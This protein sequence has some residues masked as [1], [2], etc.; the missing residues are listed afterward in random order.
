MSAGQYC[1]EKV[2]IC[3]L[4]SVALRGLLYL[5]CQLDSVTLRLLSAG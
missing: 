5:V 2:V 3:Q 4:D 1:T